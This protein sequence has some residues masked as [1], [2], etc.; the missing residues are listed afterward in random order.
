MKI[1]KLVLIAILTVSIY[2][3]TIIKNNNEIS[4]NVNVK[5]DQYDGCLTFIFAEGTNIEQRRLARTWINWNY[6]VQIVNL[7]E[8]TSNSGRIQE[9]WDYIINV[10][11][12]GRTRGGVK[13]DEDDKEEDWENAD[14]YLIYHALGCG[15]TFTHGF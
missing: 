4:K 5:V 10:S 7:R 15:T 6:N 14:Q 1:L 8:Q 13:N 2:S 12:D 3:F 11:E 9:K